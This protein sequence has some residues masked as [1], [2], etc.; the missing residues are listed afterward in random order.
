VPQAPVGD[1][2]LE[3]EVLGDPGL[4][5]M[6]LV[7]GW[8][9]Q[10][11]DWE[12]GFC[13]LL[14]DQGFRVVRFDNRD[15]GLSGPAPGTSWD[16]A[17]EGEETGAPYT[18]SDMAAD[19]VGLLDHLGVAT[20]HVA[21]VS[22][23]GMIAQ[24]L[25]IE[26]P[27]RVASLCS[28]LSTTGDPA[29]GQPD[30]DSEALA[31]LARLFNEVGEDRESVVAAEVEAARVTLGPAFRFD[32]AAV[33]QRA[34]RDYDRAFR[35]DGRARQAAAIARQP[36]RTQALSRLRV[37]TLVVHGDAD[38]LVGL[39]GGQATAKAIPGAELL[40]IPGLGHSLPEE[41]WP[42]VTQAM[43]ANARRA[44]GAR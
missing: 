16:R 30:P 23:G 36:D 37:P 38:P 10:L 9:S 44:G 34:E 8:G 20:A 19:C 41:V 39:S 22:M 6:L 31:V 42:Q 43:A 32:E 13:S 12:L 35:P 21:G 17:A 1:V 28:L 33:R 15:S 24:T 4:P 5:V 18:L 7:C 14:V 27:A 2:R 29:V 25:A 11:V 40:V 26:H 3:Y